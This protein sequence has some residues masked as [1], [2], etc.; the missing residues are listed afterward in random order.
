MFP[1]ADKRYADKYESSERERDDDMARHS[2][3]VWQHAQHIEREHEHEECED[4]G[5]ILHPVGSDVVSDHV[6]NELV[7]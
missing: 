3:G 1:E 7:G 4:E 5:E 6:G 2:E